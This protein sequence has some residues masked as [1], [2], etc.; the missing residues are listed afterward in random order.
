MFRLGI[1]E[2]S[3]VDKDVLNSLEKYYV[4]QRLQSV[5]E[6]EFPIWHI[7]EYHLN[8]TIF[9]SVLD[10]L[11]W[12]IKKTWYCHAFSDEKLYVILRGKWF[13]VSLERDDTWND[14]I[15]YGINVAEVEE[16]YLEHIPLHV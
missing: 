2:E 4:S 11:I 9:E 6:D 16:F 15:E 1:I 3:L 13:V 14:M 7:N 12:Q 10:L 8:D 5:P